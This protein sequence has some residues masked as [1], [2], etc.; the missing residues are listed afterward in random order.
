ML[1]RAC[2]DAESDATCELTDVI[3]TSAKGMLALLGYINEVEVKGDA[4]PD[5]AQD[6]DD[7]FGRSFQWF[8]QRNMAEWLRSMA[9]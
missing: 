6:E 5:L 7:R 9:A 1:L 3:P 4:W 2:G 8:T